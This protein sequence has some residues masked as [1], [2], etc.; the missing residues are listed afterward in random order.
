M[1]PNPLAYPIHAKRQ[2]QYAIAIQQAIA[3][4]ASQ[5]TYAQ[6]S[7]ILKSQNLSI[8]RRAFYNSQRGSDKR[9][10][11]ADLQS[12]FG[13]LSEKGYHCHFRYKYDMDL[14]TA[15]PVNRCLEML[16]FMSDAQI[17]WAQRFCSSFMVEVDTTCNTN[18]L[19]LPL[20]VLTGKST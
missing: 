17:Q 19:R 8:D 16:F 3:L 20:T 4:R 9:Q 1:V 2:P 7:R 15:E 5:I 6:A 12:L 18:S 14:A 11:E 13:F 10:D